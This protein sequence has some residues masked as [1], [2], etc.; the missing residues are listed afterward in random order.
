[1]ISL[2]KEALIEASFFIPRFRKIMEDFGLF[3][4]ELARRPGGVGKKYRSNHG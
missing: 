3:T 2:K 4:P 1:M